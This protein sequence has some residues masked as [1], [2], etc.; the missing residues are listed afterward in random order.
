[1]SGLPCTYFLLF[2][3][4]AE[5]GNAQGFLTLL[6]PYNTWLKARKKTFEHFV[7]TYPKIAKCPNIQQL[8]LK[9]PV[10]KL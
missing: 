9:H 8:I 1:M 5:E 3:R 4:L 10:K 6:R 2:Y 7:K